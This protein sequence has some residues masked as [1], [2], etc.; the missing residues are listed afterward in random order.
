MWA[1]TLMSSMKPRRGYFTDAYV[2]FCNYIG[3]RQ[4]LADESCHLV[5]CGG[6][7]ALFNKV[8]KAALEVDPTK[9]VKDGAELYSLLTGNAT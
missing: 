6:Y 2:N 5:E 3:Y 9:W 4:V 7:V 8:F 1:A